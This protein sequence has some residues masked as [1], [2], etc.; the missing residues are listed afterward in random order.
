MGATKHGIEAVQ[1]SLVEYVAVLA[2]VSTRT[3]Y[4]WLASG[5]LKSLEAGDVRQVLLE[6]LGKEWGR[7]R[8]W[9]A[10]RGRPFRR[11]YDDRR[12]GL[13]LYGQERRWV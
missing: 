8:R 2:G 7:G 3:V 9:L 5:R 10:P 4:R 13:R 12:S 1:M 6:R 11:G